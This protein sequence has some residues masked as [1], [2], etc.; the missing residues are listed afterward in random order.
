ML[1]LYPYPAASRPRPWGARACEA[2]TDKGLDLDDQEGL[3]PVLS[4]A[5]KKMPQ[6]PGCQT[7]IPS[8]S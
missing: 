4:A 8:R 2:E 5:A 1:C 3:D 7:H 6:S